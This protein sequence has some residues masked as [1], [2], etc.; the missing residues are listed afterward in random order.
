MRFLIVLILAIVGAIC[1]PIVEPDLC[2]GCIKLF[3]D[4]KDKL[5]TL[6][7]SLKI[8]NI[9]DGALCDSFTVGKEQCKTITKTLSTEYL[10]SVINSSDSRT[11][12]TVLQYCQPSPPHR[13]DASSHEHLH[14]SL[15][16]ANR[17]VHLTTKVGNTNLCSEC[18]KLLGD[19]K[20]QLAD[21][22]TVQQFHLTVDVLFCNHLP[23]GKEQCQQLS[24]V[25][26]NSYLGF[27]DKIENPTVCTVL[28]YCQPIHPQGSTKYF[29]Q[30][31]IDLMGR[32]LHLHSKGSDDPDLC[33]DCTTLFG[34]V[35]TRLSDPATIATVE[36]LFDQYVCN[37]FLI[38][39]DTCKT[40]SKTIIT[41][42][43]GFLSQLVNP[44]LICTTLLYCPAPLIPV[45][46]G[47]ADG[48]D[49][50]LLSRYLHLQ[51]KSKV[52]LSDDPDLCADCTTLFGDVKTRLSD[53]A[54]IATIE[55]LFNQYVCNFF[56]IGKDTCKTLSKTII[57]TYLGFLAQL[58]SPDLICTT[59][60]YC[61]AAPIQVSAGSTDGT[62]L[63][64]LS[65]YL[66]LQTKSK[67]SLSDDPDLCADCTTLFGDVKTRLSDPATIATIEGL[68]NQYVCNFFLIGK[69]TCK[70]LSNTIITTYMGLLS[71][72]VNPD[73]ICTTLLYCPAPLLQ[74]S[75]GSTDGTDV[76]FLSRYL[77][78][79]TKSK[80][81]STDDPDL[82]ADCTTLFGDVKTRLSDPTTIATIEGLF[83]QYVCNFFLIGKGTCKTL[84]KT[85]I[86]TYMGFLSQLVNPYL[87]CTTLLYCPAQLIQVSAG[88]AN[89]TDLYFLSRYLHL[90]TKSKVSATD[91]PD[92]CADCTTLFG[93]VKTRLSDPATIATIEGL[94]NQYVCNFFLIGKGTCKTL[95]NTIITTYMGFLSQ[96]VQPDL[97]C[98]TLLYCPAAPIQVS[99]GSADGTDLYLLSRYLNLQAKSKVSLS[100]DPDLC[101]DC[102]TL[103]ADVKTR[104]SDPA[105]IATVEGL[106]NQ[107]V[108][109]L[110]LIGK[111]TCKTLSNTII[112]TYLGFLS[113]LVNPDL[114][115]TTLLYC[116]APL[117]QV[118]AGSTDGTDLYFLARYLHLQTK[119]KVS[120]TDDPDLCADCTTLF[121]DVKTRLSD[122]TTIATIEG[123]FN[124]YVCN[125]F[126]IGKGTCKTLSKTII[127]TYMGFLS[128]LVN[129]DL[130]CTTLL[131]CPA[132]LIQVS[133]GSA[134]GTDLYFLSRYLHLQTKSKVSATDD[135]DLCADCTTLFGDV[136][137]R[138][139]DP[140]TIA[141]IEGLFNQ[142]V[143][144][145]FLIGK[146]TCKTLSKTIITTYLGFLSQLVN[147][148]LICTTLLYC[149]APLIQVSTGSPHG[150]DLYF[151]SRY[152]HLQTK[153]KVSLADDPDL[154][155]D[156]TTLFG[157]VKTR[158]S[159][160]A[161]IA[162]IE[163]LFNQ[164]VCNF[165]LI[166]KGTCKTLSNTIITTYMGFLSQLVQPDLICT[167]LLYCPAA[168]IPVSAGSTDGTDLYFLSRYLHLQ[169][170]SKVSSTDDPDLCADCTTLFGD[171]KTRLSDPTT[172]AT[173]EGLFNQYVCNFFL[174]GKDTCKTLSK[175]IITTYMGF[176]SQLVNPDLICT[177][178]LYCPAAPTRP[179]P[180]AVIGGPDLCADCTAIFGNLKTLLPSQETTE[181]ISGYLE[182]VVCNIIPL[183]QEPCSMMI[184]TFV[185]AALEFLSNLVD[186]NVICT[187]L[188]YCPNP[189]PGLL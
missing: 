37:F 160:P 95:S 177:T 164:Y 170:K 109:N 96:L 81:S 23:V 63:Y 53:P 3:T 7:T 32:Y 100:D 39:K 107:Y 143:C 102:T 46:T 74:E 20:T 72:L 69:D 173:I 127:T 140:A 87:I 79:Q 34:D 181:T 12:C 126:L 136:K 49:L 133:A 51:T 129:P 98:T 67:I 16:L 91:D 186:V 11:I 144:N 43:M 18:S 82:C 56:L 99:A 149:P 175:T 142:Y 76:Y 162:T 66:H 155:A 179:E 168:P 103:F 146:D 28:L 131:Y 42:Y 45:S 61:P 157:D 35:K 137:T 2:S 145:F 113:Q 156:C 92:L 93:D 119:S 132:Q 141:T 73:L 101:A 36:G 88:S 5:S 161:T 59:L 135:P 71:Q 124:Q 180:Q 1:N 184:Q 24:K 176:L 97:I 118:S 33:A 55:G 159:D 25:V 105:T 85:I 60:L 188:G 158:L 57:T 38:G 9:I 117:L 52:S 89:G 167:T 50:Y 114:I 77:H 121:G 171:V 120:S 125:F 172:I 150:T 8:G 84:S 48:T 15:N 47:S 165:F 4:V 30:T 44:D 80:V 116:P 54:T 174:I 108:C 83:N 19:V 29:H 13:I 130:I 187:A 182:D 22:R 17:F 112:T 147:P 78:L 152:L 189:P 68:F 122:P 138:L 185:G 166:G 110:F 27:L 115:C 151:L 153:S 86:T 26:M 62:D 40:L 123:L 104:L 75:A 154:C 148:D 31:D 58:V 70:T 41:I 10:G 178:L 14:Q 134:N 139:S 163:G 90:Q 106:F 111:D 128:Q 64:F 94:F 169:T 183:E 6:E 65:R 21:P